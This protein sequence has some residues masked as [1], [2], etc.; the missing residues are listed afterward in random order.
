MGLVW[1]LGLSGQGHDQ[2]VRHYM[3]ALWGVETRNDADRCLP[4]LL[5]VLQLQNPLAA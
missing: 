3:S 4:V 1:S 5:R 2:R